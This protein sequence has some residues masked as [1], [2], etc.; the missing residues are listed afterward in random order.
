M[1]EYDLKR[2][3]GVKWGCEEVQKLNPDKH[4]QQ[5]ETMAI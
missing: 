3:S 1:T 4:H 2:L 5:M